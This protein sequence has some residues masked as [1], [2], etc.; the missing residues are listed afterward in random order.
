MVALVVER[1]YLIAT[2]GQFGIRLAIVIT[3][4]YFIN[5]RRQDLDYRADLASF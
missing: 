5:A 3:E 2:Q 1:D 4:F